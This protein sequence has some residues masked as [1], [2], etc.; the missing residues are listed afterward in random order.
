[1]GTPPASSNEPE[2][3][4]VLRGL[5]SETEAL[6]AQTRVQLRGASTPLLSF[7]L[8]TLLATPFAQNAFNFAG[9]GRSIMSYPLFAYSELTDLCVVHT[10]G[11][12]CRTG[13]FDGAVLRFLA[14]GIWFVVVPMAWFVVARWYRH[15]GETRGVL[16]RRTAWIRTAVVGTVVIALLLLAQLMLSRQPLLSTQVWRADQLV[17][18]FTSPWYLVGIGLLVLGLMERSWIAAAAGL[19]HTLLLSAYLSYS[20]GL[21]PWQDPPVQPG[22]V[23]GPQAKA[24]L[25]AAILLVAGLVQR[26]AVDRRADHADHGAVA[27]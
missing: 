10:P 26:M 25:L 2:R 18:Q 14:W 3:R 17:N 6:R 22:W 15:R 8:L 19:I 11:T 13:E 4:T 20:T 12:P 5:L 27:P 24:A 7:G 21:T 23:D 1:M 9:H 16:P